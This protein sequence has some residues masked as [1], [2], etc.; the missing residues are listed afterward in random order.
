MT[1]TLG[2]IPGGTFSYD[3]NDQLTT[4]TYDANGNTKSSGGITRAY[5]FEDHLT[6]YGAVVIQNDGD[7]NRVSETIGGVTTKFWWIR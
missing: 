4:D 1:S 2:A 5:D 6:G 7:G 3:A